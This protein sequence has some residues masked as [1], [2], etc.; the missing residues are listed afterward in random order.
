M[1][2]DDRMHRVKELA[3]RASRFTSADRIFKVWPS[4]EGEDDEIL[5]EM[6]GRTRTDE[7]WFIKRWKMTIPQAETFFLDKLLEAHNEISEFLDEIRGG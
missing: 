2:L 7:Y 1:K 3:D 4:E 5:V 6:L